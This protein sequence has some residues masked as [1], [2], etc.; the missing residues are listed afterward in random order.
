[1]TL[2]TNRILVVDDDEDILEILSLYLHN[3]GFIVHTAANAAEAIKKVEI[4]TFD[5]II[6]DILL[7]DLEGT[8]LCKAIRKNHY[9]PIMF[10]S[11]IDDEGYI[12]KAFELGGDDYIKKP[13]NTKELV[14]RVKANLR[15]VQ[16][17]KADK[18]K[19][20]TL[21]TLDS[22]TFDYTNHVIE[23]DEDKVY[24]SP[25]EFDILV[26]MINNPDKILSYSDIYKNIWN[27]DSFGDTRTVMVHVSNL[28][29]K[30]E[31][32]SGKS[33]IQTVKKMGYKFIY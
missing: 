21:F 19:K 31:H 18:E 5:L 15:R 33:Y 11:C 1:M 10:I 4:S 20:P 2:S 9:C 29:K 7:P 6:L 32:I 27:T 16:Y 17:D 13:F 12:L 26:Y 24:L 8:S 30:L 14:A 28:R 3:A 22:L 23:K 25:T